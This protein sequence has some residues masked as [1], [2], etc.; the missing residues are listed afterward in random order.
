MTRA[1]AESDLT[2]F[3]KDSPV[4]NMRPSVFDLNTIVI[5]RAP[6]AM[7]RAWG[8]TYTYT[9]NARTDYSNYVSF[10][11]MKQQYFIR[12]VSGNWYLFGDGQTPPPLTWKPRK[13]RAVAPQP[14]AA[15]QKAAAQEAAA[16]SAIS[17]VFS[18]CMNAML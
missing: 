3:F 11:D 18:E 7:Q 17:D 4:K 9:V 6:K 10:W 1:D 5:A 16:I 2:G 8:E 14:P 12:H 13:A 15:A